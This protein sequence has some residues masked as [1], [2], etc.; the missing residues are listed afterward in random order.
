MN[1]KK[2]IKV[3]MAMKGIPTQEALANKSGVDKMTIS[4]A[5]NNKKTSLSTIKKIADALEYSMSDFI[6]LGE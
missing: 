2:S 6:A 4:G 1:I 5:V 3:A